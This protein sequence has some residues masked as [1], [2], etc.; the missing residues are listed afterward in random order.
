MA[1]PYLMGAPLP[2]FGLFG[3]PPTLTA[4]SHNL[5]DVDGGTIVTLTGTNL[6]TTTNCLVGGTGATLV[7]VTSTSVSFSMPAKATGTYAV[8]VITTGGTS[9][10]LSIDAWHPGEYPLTMYLRD[11]PG[12]GSWPDR[13]SAGTSGSRGLSM[14]S[15]TQGSAVTGSKKPAT[16]NGTS[17]W[18]SGSFGGEAALFTGGAG[19]AGTV[20]SLFRK[21]TTWPDYG[22][23]GGTGLDGNGIWRNPPLFVSSQVACTV[24][25]TG[26]RCGNHPEPGW[27]ASG[28]PFANNLWGLVQYRF[29]AS[30]ESFYLNEASTGLDKGTLSL[31]TVDIWVGKSGDTP[32]EY[33][34]GD[35]L[36]LMTSNIRFDDAQCAKVLAWARSCYGLLLND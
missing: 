33:L 29:N 6:G 14:T 28:L 26:I 22:D 31:T 2:S 4:I 36:C 7:G 18:S 16:Y 10:E 15:V 3:S 12:G 5:V 35:I 20:I 27:R 8:K 34:D 17:S 13:V 9:N 21:R 19:T 32:A 30:R 1:P 25:S 11:Y 23:N 24:S